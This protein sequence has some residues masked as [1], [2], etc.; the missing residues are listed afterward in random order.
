[1]MNLEENVKKAKEETR[2]EYKENRKEK[3]ERLEEEDP[4]DSYLESIK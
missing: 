1:M 2:P 4:L 3:E